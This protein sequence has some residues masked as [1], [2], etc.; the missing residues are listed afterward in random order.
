MTSRTETGKHPNAALIEQLYTSLDRHDYD[1]MARC[2]A[3]DATFRDIAFDLRGA[4]D[5]R[6]MWRM[7]ASGDIRAKFDSVQAKDREGGARVIDEYT[8]GDTGRRVLNVIESH[9][10]FRDGRI[11]EHRDECD[12][13]AWGK[14]ALGGLAGVLAGRFRFLRSR[15]ARKKLQTFVQ[16]HPERAATGR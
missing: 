6:A 14:M 7:I 11:I 2:Y 1:A 3:P 12:A 15:K 8:F 5:I 16:Q 13:G 9:F 10:R 4:A